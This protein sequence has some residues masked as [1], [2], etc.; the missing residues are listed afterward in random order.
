VASAF[1][2]P[3]SAPC[4]TSTP[5]AQ[6]VLLRR[7]TVSSPGSTVL[8]PSEYQSHQHAAATGLSPEGHSCGLRKHLP[9]KLALTGPVLPSP[10]VN[11]AKPP[12]IT[13]GGEAAC[14]CALSESSGTLGGLPSLLRPLQRPPADAHGAARGSIGWAKT[15]G[16]ER[17]RSPKERAVVAALIEELVEALQQPT[18]HA[19]P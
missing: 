10:S 19:A 13:L 7:A 9:Q 5:T 8:D 2:Y 15:G 18:S 17:A 11:L 4:T 3:P 6:K 1:P 12:P 16:A 14:R